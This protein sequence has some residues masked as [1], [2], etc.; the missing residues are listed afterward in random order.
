MKIDP[1]LS[2]EENLFCQLFGEPGEEVSKWFEGKG[3]DFMS[4]MRNAIDASLAELPERN[5]QAL[6]YRCG[7]DTDPLPLSFEKIGEK[8]SVT[9]ERARQLVAKGLRH[10]RNPRR[11]RQLYR[12]TPH[13]D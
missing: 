1:N 5:A 7:L 13:Y 11:V 10:L 6:R 2:P 12:F 3:P 8:F 9:R 4:D